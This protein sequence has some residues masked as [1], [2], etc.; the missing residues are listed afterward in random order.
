MSAA[1]AIPGQER[2]RLLVVLGPTASGKSELGIFLARELG[3]EILVCDSTQVYRHFD[4]GTAKVPAA[5]Q[6]GIPHH[7]MDLV[8]AEEVFT[9]GEYRRRATAALEELRGRGALPILTAGTGLYLRA[10]LEGLADAPERSEELR[11]RLRAAGERRGKA[12]LHRALERLDRE[13]AARVAPQDTHKVIRALEMRL[14][15]GKPVGEIHRS[16]RAGLAG[17]EVIKIGLNPAR[18]VLNARINARV[19]TM[20]ESGWV[21]EVRGLRAR[22]VAATAK[23]FEFIGYGELAEYLEGRTTLAE[24]AARIQQATRQFAKRQVTWFRR[25]AGVNWLEGFGDDE[26]IQGAAM[27]LARAR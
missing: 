11:G 18:A 23:P 14:I 1:A 3:G 20:L 4:I 10:L 22:G 21:E 7:L 25:E 16:G 19:E 15:A 8:E 27:E 6:Q 24:A 5:E 13:A 9:A 12:W 26:R 17:Y 2:G